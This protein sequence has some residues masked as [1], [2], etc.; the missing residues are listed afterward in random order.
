MRKMIYM[1]LNMNIPGLKEWSFEKVEALEG[2][3][4]ELSFPTPI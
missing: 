3:C 4:T 1:N 2:L